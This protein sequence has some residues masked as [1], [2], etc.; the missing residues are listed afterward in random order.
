MIHTLLLSVAAIAVLATAA[1]AAPAPPMADGATGDMA[2][3]HATGAPP[4]H[5]AGSGMHSAMMADPAVH[6]SMLDDPAM[7][8]HMTEFGIDAEQMRRWHDDGR[9]VD[10]MHEMHAEQ[11]I[12]VEAMEADCPMLS[13]DP[14]TSMHGDG[15]HPRGHHRPPGR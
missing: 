15:G 5:S 8:A 1:I 7:Q 12:D 2:S 3:M 13:G 11:G 6:E 14:M 4:K 10:E 9:T